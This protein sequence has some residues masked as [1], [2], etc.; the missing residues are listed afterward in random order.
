MN[1]ETGTDQ[2]ND[3][4][5][6]EQAFGKLAAAEVCGNVAGADSAVGEGMMSL[7]LEWLR[8]GQRADARC[9]SCT[10]LLLGPTTHR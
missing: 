1:E 9:D 7:A 2:E 6:V 5:Y 10:S 8:E 3:Q 4:R